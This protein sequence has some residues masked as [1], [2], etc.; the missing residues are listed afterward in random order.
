MNTNSPPERQRS[1]YMPPKEPHAFHRD[2]QYRIYSSVSELPRSELD[3]ILPGEPESWDFYR[4]VESV[5]P[6]LFTLKIIAGF[7]GSRLL[8]VA[9]LFYVTYR[10]D[11]PLQGALRRAGNWIHSRVPYLTSLR[12]IGL[13]SPMSDNLTIGF[14]SHLALED[15]QRAFEGLLACLKREAD[16]DKSAVVAIKS[17]DQLTGEMHPILAAR[18]YRRVTSV[19]LVMLDLPYRSMDDYLTSLPQKTASYLRRK[20]RSAKMVRVEYR[21]DIA[22]LESKI[23]ALFQSTLENSKVDYGEFEQLHPCYFPCVVNGLGT[24]AQIVLCWHEDELLSFQLALLGRNRL[25]AKQI[26][27]KYPQARDFNLYFVNWLELIDFAIAKRIPRI[28]MGATTYATK[29]LFG[30]Y[31]ERRWLYFRF[32]NT[33]LNRI[34]GPIAPLFDF[35]KNDHELRQL[36]PRWLQTMRGAQA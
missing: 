32:R 28:E 8:V 12:V 15:R 25:I 11:T 33:V 27:M 19:P 18:N 10:I 13:G 17:M 21:R 6:P 30:G 22:G 5:P 7:E 24:N 9:P 14:A 34:T 2:I 29:L 36:D 31:L 16:R 35:E 26:G 20:N 23:Y 1:S 4:V 3:G